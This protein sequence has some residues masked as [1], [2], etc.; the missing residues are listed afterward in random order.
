LIL[1]SHDFGFFENR[2]ELAS[3]HV[4]SSEG[5][6]SLNPKSQASEWESRL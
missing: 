3:V 4:M 5:W 2:E 6:K 1:A